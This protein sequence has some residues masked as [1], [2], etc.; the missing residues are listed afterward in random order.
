MWEFRATTVDTVVDSSKKVLETDPCTHRYDRLQDTIEDIVRLGI[1][2]R[3][4]GG[5]KRPTVQLKNASPPTPTDK[6]DGIGRVIVF[7]S[8]LGQILR[9]DFRHALRLR[10]ESNQRCQF[11]SPASL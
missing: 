8:G 6:T 2:R 9:I 4:V 1:L 3:V 10:Q 5:E 11:E 7:G